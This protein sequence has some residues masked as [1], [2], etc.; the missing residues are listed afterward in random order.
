MLTQLEARKDLEVHTTV[1]YSFFFRLSS[2]QLIDISEAFPIFRDVD[3]QRVRARSHCVRAEIRQALGR[4]GK[5]F[6]RCERRLLATR[7]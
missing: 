4:R 3:V 7:K 5:S 1:W 2:F 6:D